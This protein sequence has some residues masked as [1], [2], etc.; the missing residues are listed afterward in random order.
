AHHAVVYARPV[1]PFIGRERELGE[2][3]R[4]LQAALSGECHF[5]V[6]SGEVGIGKS[7]LLE[8][9]EKLAKARKLRVLH[10]R[11]VEQDRAFPYQGFCEAIQEYFRMKE[12][13]D[14][15]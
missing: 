12:A 11:F 8:E 3:Q 15:S 4:R 14:S 2:L 5:V 7:R 9:L 1:F 10:G 13:G 6:V